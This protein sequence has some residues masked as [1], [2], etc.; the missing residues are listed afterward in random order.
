MHDAEP[1][2][3]EKDLALSL[4][5]RRVGFRLCLAYLECGLHID[6]AAFLQSA[7]IFVGTLMERKNSVKARWRATAF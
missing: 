2:V 1:T 7:Q 3:P 4:R 5:G 6:F